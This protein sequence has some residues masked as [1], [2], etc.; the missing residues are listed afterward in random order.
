MPGKEKIEPTLE[1]V[2]EQ[3]AKFG[4]KKDDYVERNNTNELSFA[5]G[6]AYFGFIEPEEDTSG[7]YHDLSY[8]VFP[9]PDEG[10]WLVSIGVGTL[11]FKN[12]YELAGL[13]GLRRSIAPLISA[14]GFCKTSFL[15]IETGLPRDFKD[16]HPHFSRLFKKY[17][18]VLPS[19]DVVED[20]TSG[21]GKERLSAF[22]AFYAKMRSWPTNAQHR[23]TVSA[24]LNIR[25]KVPVKD[26]EIILNLLKT[27]RYVI[28]EGAPGTG[29]TRL[30]KQ[31][32]RELS[33]K[34]FFTQLHAETSYSD[35]IYGIRPALAERELGYRESF[36]EFYKAL[37][38]AVDNP[39]EKVLL[40]VDEINR[41]NLSNI[42]GPIF[43]LFEYKLD[44]SDTDILIGG[45]FRVSKIPE[46]FYVVATM[47]TAD[48]SL[49]VVDFAL[50]RRFAW[51]H[52]KP[53]AVEDVKF[54]DEDFQAFAEIFNWYAEGMELELQP[55][56]GYFFADSEDDMKNRVRY[57][58]FPLIKEYL[59]EGALVKAKEEF[60]AYFMRRIK[61]SLVE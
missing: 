5:E 43:Y 20:P 6:I 41:A 12:D 18:K 48:R 50:R 16:Q 51:Y 28:L 34:P 39:N 23:T 54:F 36:G 47:N 7:P 58:L 42:L 61:Q 46:N 49:A 35:F 9:N 32:S 24:A 1:F 55:G 29:K 14:K 4:A 53:K 30:A 2:R 3:A 56:Q 21:E 22:L 25:S 57:E 31:M 59:A 19:L 40:I 27:R 33:A 26:E 44:S 45:N 60:N 38:Y 13:P 8:V 37:K 10:S 17:E 15:D 52:L 11:G